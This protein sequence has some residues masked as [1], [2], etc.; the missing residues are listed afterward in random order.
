MT[1]IGYYEL[2]ECPKCRQ[3]HIKSNYASISIY[4][5]P[6][7]MGMPPDAHYAPAELKSCQKCGEKS[8]FS[9]YILIGR[10]EP[11]RFK[12]KGIDPKNLFPHLADHPRTSPL[13]DPKEFLNSISDASFYQFGRKIPKS[14]ASIWID[15]CKKALYF[16]FD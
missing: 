7:P 3:I 8:A 13:P 14:F 16:S 4:G 12:E 6:L 5:P 10:M 15:K 1:R 9:K 2:Y 11:L